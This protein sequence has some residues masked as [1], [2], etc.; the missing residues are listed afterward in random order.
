MLRALLFHL[1]LFAAA[2][3]AQAQRVQTVEGYS[4][5]EQT[6]DMTG[7]TAR[8]KV[9]EQARFDAINAAFGSN[10]SQNNVTFMR[11]ENE[12]NTTTF[13]MMG[14]SDLRGT[15][16]RDKEKPR[17]EKR[18]IDGITLWEAWVKGEA[19]EVVRAP[20]EF[21]WQLLANGLDERF[22][23]NELH[24][25]DA[26]YVRFRSPVNGYLMM[27][28]ADDRGMVTCLLPEDGEDYCRVKA[29]QWL[30]FHHN[31][32]VKEEHWLAVLPKN[33]QEE[34]DQLYVVFSPNKL[35]PPNRDTN[36][37]NSDLERYAN[38]ERKVK[39]ISGLSF[40][41]FHKY[42]GRLQR[43]DK[44]VQVEKML[45]KISKRIYLLYVKLKDLKR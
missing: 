33:R 20:V 9:I 1:L 12:K 25:G 2:I 11:T 34:Y 30:L 10:I 21:Q 23:V 40:K 15:W 6:D 29:N 44:E 41:H 24:D 35:S 37:D 3:A 26:F 32:Y 42:L 38:M 31:P 28:V 7:T 43:S 17:V 22:Q 45:V 18:V 16:I 13:Y 14:E 5:I 4:R 36:K 39:H 27:F 8:A 19:R